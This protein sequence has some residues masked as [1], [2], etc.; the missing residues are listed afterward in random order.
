MRLAGCALLLLS[1][2]TH[3]AA[4]VTPPSRAEPKVEAPWY[5]DLHALAKEA[6][7]VRELT[8]TQDFTVVPLDDAP[9]FAEYDQIVTRASGELKQE[10]MTTLSEFT[11]V[12]LEK[13]KNVLAADLNAVRQEQLIAF[14]HFKSHRL[15]VRKTIPAVLAAGSERVRFI[16]LAHEVGH[17]L[18]DQLGVGAHEVKTFDEAITWRAILEGD[19]TLTA[20]LLDAVKQGITPK[21]AVERARLTLSSLSLAQMIEVS[22]LSTRL[23][24]APPVVRELTLFPYFRGQRFISDL[25]AA[26]GLSLV[27]HALEHPPTRS[28][29]VYSPQR[30]LDGTAPALEPLGEPP[31]RLGLWWLRTLLEQCQRDK[32]PGP[33]VSWVESHYLDDSFH[34]AGQ[35]LSWATEWD[36]SA[37]DARERGLVISKGLLTCLGVPGDELNAATSGNVAGLVAFAPGADRER[38]ASMTARTRTLASKPAMPG[39]V[40]SPPALG[41]A[42]RVS[43]AGVLSGDT[44]VHAKLGLSMVV[45]GGKP[46]E[47]PGAALTIA[48]P[49]A[50]MFVMFVDEPPTQKGDDGF[51]NAVIDGFLKS[52]K[53]SVAGVSLA[54][55]HTWTP[56]ERTWTQGRE[57]KGE[58]EGPTAVHAEVFPVCGG[59]AS[60]NVVSFSFSPSGQRVA[61]AWRSSLGGTA[62]PPLCLEP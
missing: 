5:G 32:P 18:Q 37:L 28:D 39:T 15:L 42:F 6:A 10:L 60:V 22:G 12:D 49:G 24:E 4:V 7:A 50:V 14:Y 16:T 56:A 57:M 31:R 3:T 20:T 34:R 19:A 40:I 25:Y 62:Q 2:C 36:G 46:I 35:T 11:G 27:R 38:L 52:S 61:D 43:G 53:L 30:W 45:A 8:L 47:N 59:K 1:G 48:G 55:K 58:F 51:V 17:V 44:W 21:R 9:F 13:F 54:T 41:A 33:A 23:L 29:A 26:G